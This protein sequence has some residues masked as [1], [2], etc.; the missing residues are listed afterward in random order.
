MSMFIKTIQALL[1]TR[2]Y[3]WALLLVSASIFGADFSPLSEKPTLLK[4]ITFQQP[5]AGE[6]SIPLQIA[7]VQIKAPPR[8][9]DLL[10]ERANKTNLQ[11]YVYPFSGL[12]A[13]LNEY[14]ILNLKSNDIDLGF[15]GVNLELGTH[16]KAVMADTLVHIGH[17]TLFPDM[18]DTRI[19]FRSV[20][21]VPK[22]VIYS[23]KRKVSLG[24]DEK[25]RYT[26]QNVIVKKVENGTVTASFAPDSDLVL[27]KG[28]SLD[29][30]KAPWLNFE[31]I[32]PKDSS[33]S[34]QIN[35]KVDTDN[36]GQNIT[37]L[38]Q[39]FKGNGKQSLLL[40]LFD[41]LH[42]ADP[43]AKRGLL[44][45]LIIHFKPEGPSPVTEDVRIEL[46]C[47]EF[48]REQQ[49]A[50]GNLLPR[51]LIVSDL[52]NPI[53]L[54]KELNKDLNSVDEL[55]VL[56]GGLVSPAHE[57][58]KELS[59]LPEI[60][61]QANYQETIPKSFIGE[62]F[63]L[64]DLNDKELS[65]VLDQRLFLEKQV[66][67]QSGQNDAVFLEPLLTDTEGVSL[68]LISFAPD[69]TVENDAYIIADY[70]FEGG[71]QLPLYL[72]LS[73]YDHQG[74]QVNFD[75]LLVNNIPIKVSNIDLTKMNI[76][77]RQASSPTQLPLSLI[78]KNIQINTFRK[79]QAYRQ[80][81]SSVLLS[82]DEG[83]APLDVVWKTVPEKIEFIMLGKSAMQTVK[84]FTINQ[85]I[86]GDAFVGFNME[87]PISNP[88][89]IRV[90]GKDK[91]KYFEKLFPIL[92][93]GTIKL[94]D[95]ELLGLDLVVNN[96]ITR[97]KATVMLNLLN[98]RYPDN[99]FL[100]KAVM[101]DKK[102]RN[103]AMYQAPHYSPLNM[104]MIDRR[105]A[106]AMEYGSQNKMEEM[107]AVMSALDTTLSYEE[108]LNG[109]RTIKLPETFFSQGNHQLDYFSNGEISVNITPE[110]LNM[111]QKQMKS[112]T[113]RNTVPQEPSSISLMV[114]MLLAG[115]ILYTT[116][117]KLLP[118]KLPP[119]L[120]HFL[121]GAGFWLAE[122][123]MV[124]TVFFIA[125][126]SG[127]GDTSSWEGIL[128]I[129]AYGFAVRN[130][131][132]PYLVKKWSCFEERLSAPYFILFLL[133][134]LTCTVFLMFDMEI[135]A[136]RM[137]VIC[138]FL[139]VTGVII[140][141]VQFTRK[142]TVEPI[143][144]E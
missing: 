57:P 125:F 36:I 76:S 53:N 47:L 16:D 139:L 107:Y 24:G 15:W 59:T 127:T 97:A 60:N 117:S 22:G 23:L 51:Q 70:A 103:Q 113:A 75:Y 100:N 94:S 64:N 35:A 43:H 130:K 41:I 119:N 13:D 141:F 27:T 128:I 137:A 81:T 31:Y 99:L 6:L 116:R 122:F 61:I 40:N 91:H 74:K 83:A 25:W 80:N 11:S 114:W 28:F 38:S 42:K 14:P 7:P 95:M 143:S 50:Q 82:F 142:S 5:K 86:I 104:K 93:R 49:P 21:V 20:E 112:M 110:H 144:I 26:P 73:G 55:I 32:L 108:I 3:V 62:A 88:W 19:D 132:R 4:S 30:K 54:V 29:I 44:K 133:L 37:L 33:W 68:P 121:H 90:K 66:L 111:I 79:T 67:W 48:Y 52:F 105:S 109:G 135:I 63:Y 98:V 45:D 56:H 136:E 85:K 101:P 39:S 77:F 124:G 129:M 10:P 46:G 89:F 58:A 102:Q 140:E 12:P 115:S 9:L 138:Y 69:V 72:N 78:V 118:S 92:Q 87:T 8:R 126:K 71:E 18:I 120:H 17:P 134:L 106:W 131:I 2:L 123:A 84:S 1:A 65:A 96:D 34:V